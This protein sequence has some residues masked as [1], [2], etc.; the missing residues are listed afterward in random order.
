[1]LFLRPVFFLNTAISGGGWFRELRIESYITRA[2]E[3][4][5]FRQIVPSGDGVRSTEF[6]LHRRKFRCQD[7]FFMVMQKESFNVGEFIFKIA[8]FM[9]IKV[10]SIIL[11][12][13]NLCFWLVIAILYSF[14]KSHTNPVLSLLLFIEPVV[15][16][17]ALIGYLNKSII[18]Y[19]LTLSFLIVNSIL[20]IADEVG[21]LDLFSLLLNIIMFILLV[22]QWKNYRHKNKIV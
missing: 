3:R 6:F 17:S 12:L 2:R 8:G 9:K 19:Y 20:S 10:F 1:M 5:G 7:R 14:V 13:I 16:L 21:V 18:I 11:F 15:F 4:D 22:L